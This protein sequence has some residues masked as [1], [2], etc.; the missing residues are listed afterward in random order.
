MPQR[1]S[2]HQDELVRRMPPGDL[3]T[4][5]KVSAALAGSLDLILENPAI[6][7]GD[8]YAKVAVDSVATGF[9]ELDAQLPGGG[10]GWIEEKAAVTD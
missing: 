2:G 6:W 8:Q 1:E 10:E 5:L 3:A 7:R 4:L 9:P